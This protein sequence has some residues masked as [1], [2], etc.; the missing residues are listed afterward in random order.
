MTIKTRINKLEQE[1][2]VEEETYFEDIYFTHIIDGD[3]HIYKMG[4][5][6][7]IR[8]VEKE[9]YEQALAEYLPIAAARGIMPACE[10]YSPKEKEIG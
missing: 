3:K 10:F 4:K 6:G 2:N 7:E 8:E 1:V 9:T 5:I